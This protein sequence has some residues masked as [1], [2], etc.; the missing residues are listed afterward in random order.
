MKHQTES[1]LPEGFENIENYVKEWAHDTTMGRLA[2]R[3]NSKFEDIVEFYDAMLPLA[4]EALDYLR[5]FQ[6]GAL[7]PEAERLMRLMLMLQEIAPAVEW[8]GDPI[9]PD[10]Y[11]Y[12]RVQIPVQIPDVAS[13]I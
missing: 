3:Y 5:Q 9:G 6:L 1:T 8:Y 4:S 10:C 11:D 12:R 7:S 13:Q 2:V